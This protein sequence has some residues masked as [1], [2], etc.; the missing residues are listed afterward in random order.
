M[1]IIKK[2]STVALSIV[3]ILVSFSSLIYADDNDEYVTPELDQ[4]PRVEIWIDAAPNETI[5]VGGQY[6]VSV[7][8]YNLE[9]VNRGNIRFRIPGNKTE[10]EVMENTITSYVGSEGVN[11]KYSYAQAVGMGGYDISIN[12]FDETV[13]FDDTG[14]K[15]LSFKIEKK[16]EGAVLFEKVDN[17]I[18]FAKETDEKFTN[19]KSSYRGK[20]DSLTIEDIIY[21]KEA[22]PDVPYDVWQSEWSSFRNGIHNNAVV[23]TNTPKE[24][25][26]KLK[27]QLQGESIGKMSPPLLVGEYVYVLG[28]AQVCRIDKETGQIDK[29]ASIGSL[30]GFNTVSP[31][32]GVIGNEGSKKGVIFV[33]FL[34]GVSAFEATTLTKLWSVKLAG[35]NQTPVIYDSETQ[36]VY[37]GFWKG[38]EADQKYYCID[39]NNGAIKWEIA[40]KGGFYWAGATIVGNYFV[41]GGDDGAGEDDQSPTGKLYVVNKESGEIV[42][43]YE[44]IKGDQRSSITFDEVT[45]KV[46]FT[47]KGGCLYSAKITDEGKISDLTEKIY[48]DNAQSTSTPVV[49]NGR[50]YFGYGGGF[51]NDDDNQSVMVADANT[52]DLIYRVPMYGYPQASALLSTAYEDSENGTVYLYITYN[53]PP[54]GITLIKDKPGQTEPDRE[55]LYA[56]GTG[57]TQYCLGSPICDAEGNIYYI[58]DSGTLFC[59]TKASDDIIQA[60]TEAKNELISK[61]DPEKYSEDA[62]SEVIDELEWA[63]RDINSADTAEAIAEAKAAAETKLTIAAITAELQDVQKQ[64]D[65][66][67]QTNASLSGTIND[68]NEQLAKAQADLEKAAEQS[69]KDADAVKALNEQLEKAKA[70]IADVQKKLEEAVAQAEA[71][72]ASKQTADDELAKALAALE[73]ANAKIDK[74]TVQNAVVKNLKASAKKK[75]AALKWKALGSGYK[76]VV[77]RSTKKNKGFKKIK[78]VTA[79]KLTVKKLKSKKTFFFKVRA[80]KTL[81]GKKVYTRYSNVAKAKIK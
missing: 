66:A 27:W 1:S 70:D 40:N 50:V 29:S 18:Y 33:E 37:V 61:Y 57:H 16:A 49:Y 68:L 21:T 23:S 53:Y 15:I 42:D 28:G 77:Y 48:V 2:A 44:Q 64:L 76:Y 39:A 43:K 45:G 3:L 35:Q 25:E 80:F 74:L 38:E 4:T 73:E 79:N 75:K 19:S 51:N 20:D 46:F 17:Y 7:F 47:T 62:A 65:A 26:A 72:A 31:A 13:S 22:L 55:E 63:K 8:A 5:P 60:R 24:R 59:L 34:G 30:S 69:G 71:D 11:C 52:L 54:G 12:P 6:E 36:S 9:S 10:E 78:T 58:N 81:G 14:T 56:P 67:N 41:V 32:Y